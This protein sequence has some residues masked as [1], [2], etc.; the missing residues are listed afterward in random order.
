[1]PGTLERAADRPTRSARI[2]RTPHLGDRAERRAARDSLL[3]T[4]GGQLERALGTFT[5]L[6]LRWWLDPAR[7]GVYTGLRMFLDNTNRSSLGVSLGAIQEIPLLRAAGR[8]DEA[9]RV[10]NVAHTT[11]TLTCALYALALIVWAAWRAPLVATTP[12]G[13]E[14]TW[15]LVAIAGL[16]VL[17]RYETF[18]VAV[19]RAHQDFSTTTRADIF[20]SIVS[21][22]AVGAGLLLAGFWGLLAAVGVILMCKIGYLSRRHPLRFAWVWDWPIVKRLFWCGLPI[23]ANT[24][25]FGCVLGIDRLVIL[26][27][28][29]DGERALGLYSIALMGSS[30]CL[31]LSGRIVLVLYPYFQTAWGQTSDRRAVA[32]RAVRATE[33][34]LPILAAGAMTAYVFGPTVL[35]ALMPRYVDGICA[36]RP[37]LPGVLLLSTAW[38]A[39]Q[40]LIATG[41]PIR[42]FIATLI[43]LSFLS[44]AAAFGARYAGLSGVAIGT[45][46]GYALI[47]LITSA[48]AFV[49]GLGWRGWMLHQSRLVAVMCYFCAGALLTAS[50]VPSLNDSLEWLVAASLVLAWSLPCAWRYRSALPGMR[51][52]P[53]ATST[54]PGG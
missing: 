41:R 32:A 49:P 47:S 50:V 51:Q 44:A 21:A 4:V 15:G 40:L 26:N 35:G 46:A 6:A 20:E 48:V 45:S 14:W 5:A 33:G 27:A 54:A 19:L 7:L 8:H 25:L 16:A 3:V 30:W 36:M 11:N 18:M 24:A 22:C 39:R 12:L 2:S 38:P 37:L 42:L 31:D 28:L 13:A 9:Q 53:V 29:P 10:A 23:L 52:L 17:K 43:G 34:Q 1:M